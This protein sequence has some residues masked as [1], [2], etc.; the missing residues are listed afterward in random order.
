MM[1]GFFSKS[2]GKPQD[3]CDWSPA[4]HAAAKVPEPDPIAVKILPT[5]LAKSP[6]NF[7]VT[8][9]PAFDHF[10]KFA[11]NPKVQGIRCNSAMMAASEI[12][13]QFQLAVSKATVPLWFDI[14]GMQ[15][16][17]KEIVCGTDC[18]HLE[19]RLNRPI[20]C[21]LPA[22]VWFKAGEDAAQ[23]VEIRDGNHLIF[24]GGPKYEVRVGE[25]IHIRNP[26]LQVLGKTFLDFEVEKIEKVKSFGFTKWYLSYVYEQRHIDEFR[27]LIGSDAELILKIEN[28]EGLNFIAK[29]YKPMPNTRLMAARG[30]LF[31][32]I[33]KPHEILE[34]CRLIIKKDPTAFVGS[35]MLL[36]LNEDKRDETLEELKIIWD[37]PEV[38]SIVSG[39]IGQRIHN[40]I[41]RKSKPKKYNPIP[42]CSDLF[43]LAGLY[44]MGYRNFL[45]CD[46][47]CLKDHMLSAATNV[48]EAFRKSYDV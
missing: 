16:R 31:I 47:L 24:K 34:A 7:H 38:G 15:L 22:V 2:S 8:L 48:F 23:L 28:K 10:H 33:D 1:F 19:F 17:I 20:E 39:P 25:S 3:N 29:K 4:A 12:D 44:E 9:W 18:D 30:D 11:T 14:K 41:V 13:D 46:E 21:N 43:E 6:V 40:M 32:E 35:R 42:S 36:S 27:E 26:E 5:P 45:L 37:K